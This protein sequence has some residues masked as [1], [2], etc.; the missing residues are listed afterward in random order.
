MQQTSTKREKS[1][2]KITYLLTCI[3]AI[4]WT[5]QQDYLGQTAKH[6]IT[7]SSEW[8]PYG[9]VN[10]SNVSHSQQRIEV[11]KMQI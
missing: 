8:G 5:T 10:L 1:A 7:S 11:E 6:L 9:M 4:P 2:N 3:T